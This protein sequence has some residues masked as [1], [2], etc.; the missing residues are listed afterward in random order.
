MK[1]QILTLST[2]LLLVFGAIGFTGC[3]SEGESSHDH[4]QHEHAAHDHYQCPMDCEDGKT[5]EEAGKCPVC[6]MDMEVVEN[7]DSDE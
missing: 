2:S 1:K 7:K 5:Y 4:D 3:G 6:K